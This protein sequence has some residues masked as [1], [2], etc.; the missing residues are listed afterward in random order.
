MSETHY[1]VLDITPFAS[2]RDI[3]RAF[4][5]K[6]KLLHPDVSGLPHHGFQKL[7][8]AYD[9]LRNSSRRAAYDRELGLFAQTAS[10]DAGLFAQLHQESPTN[11]AQPASEPIFVRLKNFI[12]KK[13][14]RSLPQT[15]DQ[16]DVA[17]KE[18]K[19]ED[20]QVVAFEKPQEAEGTILPIYT[21]ENFPLDFGES[22]ELNKLE[23]DQSAVSPVDELLECL[24]EAFS[25]TPDIQRAS[26]SEL[27]F[28]DPSK[29][30]LLLVALER[31]VDAFWGVPN[32]LEIKFS[33][34]HE[35][36]PEVLLFWAGSSEFSEA[37]LRAGVEI[38]TANSVN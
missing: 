24:R 32:I 26:I 35:M 4:Y 37:I 2:E 14:R 3:R 13:F 28:S 21:E 27:Q 30:A 31:P 16:Q 22:V 6:A 8:E 10:N 18:I 12:G 23:L 19:K 1:D 15:E 11:E 34:S 5:D 38:Y 7:K 9:V 29:G 36:L 17:S 20:E 33:T 25:K